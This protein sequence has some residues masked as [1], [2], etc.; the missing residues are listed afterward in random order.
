M[1]LALGDEGQIARDEVGRLVDALAMA[2]DAS[3]RWTFETM[4]LDTHSSIPHRAAQRGLE[5]I[6]DGWFVRDALALFDEVGIAGIH[7]HYADVDRKFGY[8]RGTPANVIRQLGGRLL[9]AGRLEE[10]A[11]IVRYDPVRYPTHPNNIDQLAERF[12][13]SGNREQAIELYSL[14]LSLSPGNVLARGGL[15]ALGVDVDAIVDRFA[16]SDS[17]L[18]AMAGNYRMPNSSV[19]TIGVADRG[20]VLDANGGH[21]E[22]IMLS[23]TE[24]TV[25]PG[26][27]YFE[28]TDGERPG[29]S[30]MRVRTPGTEWEATDRLD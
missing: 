7:A 10:V 23:A 4:E 21:E 17:S 14:A 16:L 5:F 20:L 27:L 15:A 12:L 3:F 18:D 29:R 6:F 11:E 25:G 8:Q 26:L 30:V 13:E 1:F 9:E 28:F 22:L 19:F 24:F 2:S